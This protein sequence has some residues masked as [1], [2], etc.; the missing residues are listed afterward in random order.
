MH[1]MF[2]CVNEEIAKD[3]GEQ[4]SVVHVARMPLCADGFEECRAFV[5]DGFFHR[6]YRKGVKLT[7]WAYKPSEVSK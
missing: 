7:N 3:T 2:K 6:I 5:S 1:K 4:V